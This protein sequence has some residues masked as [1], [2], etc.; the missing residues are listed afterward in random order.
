MQKTKILFLGSNW[1]SVETLKSLNE[2]KRYQIV[3]VITQP[4]KPAGRKKILT[5][6]KVK[7]YALTNNIPVF[8]TLNDKE[9]Y[10]EALELFKPELIVCKAFGEIIPGFFLEAPK[11]KAI[12]MNGC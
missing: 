7:E 10:K 6:T 11:Y 5:P 12:N 3:G 4:D 8:H 9:R 2:D 1:E